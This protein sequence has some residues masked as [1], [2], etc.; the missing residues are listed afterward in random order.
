MSV[1]SPKSP[2]RAPQIRD[3]RVHELLAT[4]KH[5]KVCGGTSHSKRLTE[6]QHQKANAHGQEKIWNKEVT[7][8]HIIAA[9]SNVHAHL[10]RS[11]CKLRP[12]TVRRSRPTSTSELRKQLWQELAAYFPEPRNYQ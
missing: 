10:S 9:L 7:N 8:Q 2:L 11:Q 1:T 3:C 12:K 4:Q 5:E 6:K